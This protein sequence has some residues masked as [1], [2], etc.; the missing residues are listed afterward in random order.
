MRVGMSDLPDDVLNRIMG[1]LGSDDIARVSRSCKRWNRIGTSY[2]RQLRSLADQKKLDRG[3]K[4]TIK[5]IFPSRLMIGLDLFKLRL[6]LCT[7]FIF[8]GAISIWMTCTYMERLLQSVC[9]IR[10]CHLSGGGTAFF[11]VIL[12]WES[13]SYTCLTSTPKAECLPPGSEVSCWFSADDPEHSLRLASEKS[14]VII[15]IVAITSVMLISLCY[16]A[17]QVFSRTQTLLHKRRLTD[18]D[19]M[20]A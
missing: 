6:L 17:K 19:V 11:V 2:Q 14:T 1:F 8:G 10:S 15:T 13:E 4:L 20:P 12:N 18:R 16:C 3:I 5:K 9:T 7:F